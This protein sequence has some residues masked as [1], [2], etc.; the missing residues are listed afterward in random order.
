MKFPPPQYIFASADKIAR[1]KKEAGHL[2]SYIKIILTAMALYDLTCTVVGG[3]A[4]YAARNFFC[5]CPACNRI[6]NERSRKSAE[7]DS[8][9][10]LHPLHF[11]CSLEIHLF[12]EK[13]S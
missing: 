8:V 4:L 3:V 1:T 6:R 7:V 10:S 5:G 9:T 13:S 11:H 12:L 2:G